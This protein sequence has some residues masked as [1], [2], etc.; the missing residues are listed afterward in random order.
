MKEGRKKKEKEGRGKYKNKEN[1][2]LKKG[3]KK[4]NY[5]GK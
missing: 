5:T 2:W 3:M 1:K 4:K